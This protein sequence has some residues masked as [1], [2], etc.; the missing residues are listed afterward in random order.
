MEKS[1]IFKYY[2]I[3]TLTSF[4]I[5]LFLIP[6][7]ETLYV[8]NITNKKNQYDMMITF[9]AIIS[10]LAVIYIINWLFNYR[11][12]YKINSISYKC[13]EK[14]MIKK[15]PYWKPFRY[16]FNLYMGMGEYDP[17]L[18]IYDSDFSMEKWNNVDTS[19]L[20]NYLKYKYWKNTKILYWLFYTT[21]FIFGVGIS[22]IFDILLLL[23][24]LDW[25]KT[26][27]AMIFVPIGVICGICLVYTLGLYIYMAIL[28]TEIVLYEIQDIDFEK[29]LQY[30][31]VTHLYNKSLE[32]YLKTISSK[33][34][35][36]FIKK[37]SD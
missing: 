18:G 15:H 36:N 24:I 9:I 7:F 29:K 10:I 19:Q 2:W 20:N 27:G 25:N 8:Y 12:I 26:T 37:Y 21:P 13:N 11:N 17:H 4:A 5:G 35:L 22:V 23:T 30:F 14:D 32:I 33:K 31:Q 28:M 34:F 3:P 1:R 16:L 6:L